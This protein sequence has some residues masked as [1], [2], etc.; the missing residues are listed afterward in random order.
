[1]PLVRQLVAAAERL[2]AEAKQLVAASR[3]N[4]DEAEALRG[5]ADRLRD[6]GAFFCGK[7]VVYVPDE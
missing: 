2:E 4:H 5:E 1:M 3:D 6:V 7:A